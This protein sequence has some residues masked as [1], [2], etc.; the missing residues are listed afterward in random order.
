MSTRRRSRGT[1]RRTFL[2]AVPS[3]LAAAGAARHVPAAANQAAA[4][5]A[6]PS[7]PDAISTA[8]LRH[9]EQLAGLTFTES[10]E[11]SMLGLVRSNRDFF[12][13]LRRVPVPA[14]TEP[15][16]GFHV[17]IPA[18][19]RRANT[20]RGNEAMPPAKPRSPARSV[21]VRAPI[22]TLAF[23]SVTVLAEIIRSRQVTSTALTNMYLERLK[24]HGRRLEAVITL[25]EDLALAQA[26]AADREIAAGRYRGPLHGIPWGVKDLFATHGIRTTW[27]AKPYEH[28]MIDTDATAVARLREAGAVLLAKLS[29]GELAQ[30]NVW[31]GG[32][33]LNPWGPARS[34][35]GSSAGP[36][37]ATAGG[38]VAFSIGTA[39]GGSIVQP[40]SAC[41]L[42][43]LQPTYGRVSRY[44]AMTLAWT[45][46][47]VGPICRSVEDCMLV[48]AA[49]AG[50]DGHDETVTD[51]PMPWN[52]EAP[53]GALRIGYVPSLFDQAPEGRGP[54]ATQAARH[55]VLKTALQA[56][57]RI[58]RLQA[59]ELPDFPVLAL[60]T[61]V[62]AE[63]GASFDE[64][65]RSGAAAQL[66][67][68]APGAR[69]SGLRAT[70]FVPA[71]EYI[72]A[73][74]IRTLLIREMNRLFA[75]VDVIVTPADL[76]IVRMTSL[77]GHPCITLKSGFVDGY[78]EAI[79]VTGSFFNE[80]V[81]A[82]VAL[83]YEQAT[84]WKDRHPT[85]T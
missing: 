75:N 52:P 57:G 37:A 84:E 66:A 22:E 33:T 83:A 43:G 24:T 80:G 17:P 18:S 72:R 15:V 26:A 47:R 58:G 44:G 42:V 61:I 38:L 29:T 11:E 4:N 53:V 12:E 73:Q 8:T 48:L 55:A 6:A 62:L 81:M 21:E 34:S 78:P 67:G 79:L 46:D 40:A 74:R 9:G 25:T 69:A 49:I 71:V 13:A 39:T 68:Q 31:F 64:L 2:R 77:T 14:D 19:A 65:V 27:G 36:G 70:R 51:V 54:A 10:E 56:F 50:P 60:F 35:G 45:L 7:Q 76:G 5:Q 28:Q 59:V 30:G 20:A 32:R 23:K 41:G 82:R 16:F 85:M 3:T 1:T 63:G